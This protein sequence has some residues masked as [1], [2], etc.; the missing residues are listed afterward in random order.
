M[1]GFQAT[2]SCRDEVPPRNPLIRRYAPPS[3]CGR[4]NNLVALSP[5]YRAFVEELFEPVFPVRI[6][7]MFGGAG[8][9]SGDVMFGLIADERVYLKVDDETRGAF[10]AEG[11]GPFVYAAPDGKHMAMGYFALPERLYDEPDEI[12]AWAMKALDVAMR[13]RGAKA[14]KPKKKR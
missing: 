7:A 5:E 3:P 13:K 6:R 12:K 10:E 4:R 11:S 1:R 8:I 14:P 2:D 9:Y